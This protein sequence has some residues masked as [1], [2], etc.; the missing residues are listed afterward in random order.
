MFYVGR[1]KLLLLKISHTFESSL[2]MCFMFHAGHFI[3]ASKLLR[4]LTC[5]IGH[6]DSHIILLKCLADSR[7]FPIAIEHIKWVEKSSP[8]TLQ[9]IYAELSV[10]LSSKSE[11]I[12]QLLQTIP[13]CLIYRDDDTWKTL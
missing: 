4:D 9:V 11:P 13:E 7:E 12:L 5:D 8:S 3:A 2:A 6:S 10:S 1:R